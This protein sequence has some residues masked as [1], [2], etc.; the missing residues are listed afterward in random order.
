M[1]QGNKMFSVPVEVVESEVFKAYKD[2][3]KLVYLYL[4]KITGESA[5]Q[6]GW[7]HVTSVT[8]HQMTGIGVDAILRAKKQLVKDG[9]IELLDKHEQHTDDARRAKRIKVKDW[10]ALNKVIS[11]GEEKQIS[12][13]F[14]A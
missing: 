2:S 5:D 13:I 8:L 7:I 9:Y 12:G 4:L 14:F 10:K 11:Q 6:Q 3:I 1:D